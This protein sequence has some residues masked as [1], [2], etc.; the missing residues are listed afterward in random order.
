MSDS[1]K[2]G[3]T[4]AGGDLK[5]KL[6]LSAVIALGVGTTVGSGIFSS[7]NEVAGAAGSSLFLVLAFLIG[8][9]VQI[10]ANLCY[11]ELATAFPEDGGQYVYFRE[12]GSRPLAFLCGWIS[13]WATD[14]PS[15][16]IMAIAIANYLAYFV[17]VGGLALK[18]IAVALVLVFMLIHLRSVE[19]GGAFQTFIT[20][21]KILPF[22]LIIGIGLFFLRGDMLMSAAPMA[23]APVGIAALLAGVSA[24]TWSFDGMAA[25]CY[26]SG[27]IKNP[28]KNIPMGLIL[29]AVVVVVIY[30]GL[31]FVS[32][33]MLSVQELASSDAPI[34][35][36]A[37]KLPEIGSAAGTVTAVMAIVV[38]IGSLSS[39]IMFQPRIEYAM[40][41]DGL[42]FKSFA[43]VHPKYETPY[44]SILVQCAVA[45]VLIFASS[46]SDLL[47][48]FTLVALLKNFLTFGTIFVL[49]RKEHYKPL[50]RMPAG[51]LMAGIAMFMTGTL[52]VSTFVWAPVAGLVCA[53]I[54]VGTGLPV[55]HFWDKR[56][57][58]NVAGTDTDVK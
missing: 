38:I 52:I 42:F 22:A 55:Y 2:A 31:T 12:A 40:A 19:G 24:T 20:A 9:L 53:A 8:G 4:T 41:K 11:A 46:L 51:Y 36:L 32:S 30:V 28:K 39:C 54:A 50:W 23:G 17:P 10:P 5:R 48:Y 27:E 47:G 45:I 57:R 26:M 7:L 14:P 29:T 21:L 56:N 34:A 6:G 3:T 15:I 44:F 49:R 13:F 33:G 58:K 35:L 37:S 1:E 43:K 25:P 18:F 16:S